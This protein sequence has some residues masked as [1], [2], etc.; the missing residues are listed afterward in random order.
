MLE[1]NAER[2][3]VEHG[4][5]KGRPK[6]TM[7]PG[8][9][10]SAIGPEELMMAQMDVVMEAYM[11]N[12]NDNSRPQGG[13]ALAYPAERGKKNDGSAGS[14]PGYTGRVATSELKPPSA[15][16]LPDCFRL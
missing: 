10:R 9:L 15:E 3:G 6:L 2:N 12:G 16:E 8:T 4:L 1:P 7:D 13:E 14:R 11:G 5:A